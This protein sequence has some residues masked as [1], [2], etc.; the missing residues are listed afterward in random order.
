MTEEQK[1]ILA[2]FI[3]EIEVER[4]DAIVIAGDLYNR[5]VPPTEAVQLLDS[6]L[7]TITL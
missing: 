5:A 3:K 4:P 2:E 6:V 7:E 1:F